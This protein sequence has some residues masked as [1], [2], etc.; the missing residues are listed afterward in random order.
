MEIRS[1]PDWRLHFAAEIGTVSGANPLGTQAGDLLLPVADTKTPEEGRVYIPVVSPYRLALSIA[2]RASTEARNVRR[3]VK[4]SPRQ[5]GRPARGI[6]FPTTPQLFDFFEQ[7]MIAATFS[8]QSLETYANIVIEEQLQDAATLTLERHKGP[9]SLN[10]AAL[11]REASTEE[12]IASVLPTLLSIP[13]DKRDKLWQKFTILRKVRD[14]IVHLKSHDHHVRGEVDK[15][16]VFYRLLNNDPRL[17]PRTAL[18]VMRLFSGGANLSWLAHAE[19]RLE[20]PA[21][22]P[23]SAV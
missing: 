4:F 22:Q 7:C 14:S 15:Q 1:L 10:A 17:Y 8:Y 18:E 13:F 6:E 16:T 3:L 2:I 21:R 9:I 12:K 11:Q 20:T 23:S 19:Q 5:N